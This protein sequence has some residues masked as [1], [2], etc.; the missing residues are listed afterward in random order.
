MILKCRVKTYLGGLLRKKVDSEV[1]M[2][3]VD[4]TCFRAGAGRSESWGAG[5]KRASVASIL[6][7]K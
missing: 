2:E 7:L 3:E 6:R 1:G 5:M 4:H